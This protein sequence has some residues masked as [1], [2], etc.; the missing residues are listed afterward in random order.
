MHKR[1]N[2]L[3]FS[4]TDLVH[5]QTDP[6]IAWMDR[7]ALEAPG[8]FEP[9]EESE[10]QVLIRQMGI[11]HERRFVAQ[12]RAGGSEP[13]DLSAAED[14]LRATLEAMRAGAAMIYQGAL[15]LDP[16]RGVPDFLARVDT[17]SALGGW[18]YEVWDAKLARSPKPHYLIQLC[19]YAEMLEAIQGRRPEE[20]AVVL[21]VSDPLRK[22]RRFRTD[23]YFY[24]YLQLKK[25]F[26]GQQ[27]SFGLENM[28]EVPALRDCG[29]WNGA[30]ARILEQRDDLSLVA[31]IRRS[32][33]RK[34]RAAGVATVHLLARNRTR[35]RGIQPSTLDRLRAQARLQL[36]SR[37]RDRPLFEVLAPNP[38]AGCAGLAAL[39]PPSP[40]DVYFDMEGYPL[41]EVNLEYL[42][43]ACHH[44]GGGLAFTDWWAV[45][46]DLEKAAF[47]GF[48]RWA[49]ARWKQ[50]P[51][52]HVYHYAAYE[53]TALRRLMGT[54]GSC[55]REV[56]DLLRNGVF[57]DLYR[58]VS[59]SLLIG[60]PAY[61]LKNAEKL[62]QPARQGDVAT[63]GDS[64]VR[65]Q[66]WLAGP[67]GQDWRTSSILRGIRDYNEADCRST[68]ALAEWLR[69][70]Q[71][72]NGIRYEPRGA[73]PPGPREETGR[74]EL[75]AAQLLSNLPADPSQARLQQMLAWLLEFH[76]RE[77]KPAWWRRFDWQAMTTEELI[78]DPDC[79]GGLRRTLRPPF[80][81]ARSAGYEY[82]F[83][84]GQETKL[85]AG[86]KCLVAADLS[87]VEL[88]ELDF[89]K[90]LAVLKSTRTDL[91][92]QCSLI[93]D[94]IVD[95]KVIQQSIERV[96]E[97]YLVSGGVA[98]A[99][100]S[101]LLRRPPR[102]RGR[103]GGPLTGE[104]ERPHQSAIRAAALLDHSA[105]CLQGPPG[106]GKTYTAARMIASLIAGGKKVAITSNSHKAI[107][108]LLKEAAA[109]LPNV[110]AVK[111]GGEDE[112][113][114]LP[115]RIVRLK[116]A[117]IEDASAAVLAGGTAWAFSRPGAAGRFDYLF[118]D[119][120]G[121]VSSANLAG[122]SPAARNLVL[123]GDQMQL[124][125]PV[126]GSHPGESGLSA[127]DYFLPGA[128][129]IPPDL[130]IFLPRTFR[131]HPRLCRFISAAVY[132]DRLLPEP[133][134]ESRVLVLPRDNRGRI[135][136]PAGILF[137]PA[138]HEDNVYESE[139]EADLIAELFAELL[140]LQATTPDGQTRRLAMD[141]IL[142]V[143]PYNLQ[144]NL[145]ERK[146]PGA[147]VGTVDR[148]Q[149]QQAPVVILSMCSSAGDSSPRG[150]PFLFSRNRLNVALSR[151][152]TLAIVVANPALARTPCTTVEQVKLVNLFCRAVEEGAPE[153][154]A[155]RAGS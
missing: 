93:P 43:G 122:M 51:D 59:Q 96:A 76:R 48:V 136:K 103:E 15:S 6:F 19:C 82:E 145:I 88:A 125:Q 110:D 11:E 87:R 63:A 9:D 131:L 134:T 86:A 35:V 58:I 32:Q 102:L 90:G 1:G 130:G 29:R 144:V 49:H 108:L 2:A 77:L 120:A 20:A 4:P 115:E 39:P 69:A 65:F 21:G 30:A 129:V 25:A 150:I 123:L 116:N 111:Y 56:D 109:L 60:E 46:H 148:F 91:P 34:L 133:V 142:V 14:P 54:H 135:R 73:P 92:A 53:V 37:G 38:E 40:G 45:T 127:L 41:G 72:E 13:L 28:P 112:A 101:F 55:E 18:S 139:E 147:R 78:E 132:E 138:E 107:N 146:I 149:G 42:F 27:E 23:D 104:S 26:L 61:S 89:E 66:K 8:R 79:L 99:L 24:Y 10:E 17:P 117:D 106:C 12:L 118:I 64:M 141:D 50:R 44:E 71:A 98:P 84:R 154:E 16:F 33:I 80:G 85:H 47:E 3:W 137:V 52:L 62:Y 155:L 94:E 126:Q 121:Q 119:E 75:L 95:P 83:E 36:G 151:A 81:I 140:E 57:V 143:A 114:D 74:R 153:E 31:N 70:R 152:E 128:A 105:L 5:Y 68:A 113:A 100:T 7:C 22:H 124:S 97:G 67:D